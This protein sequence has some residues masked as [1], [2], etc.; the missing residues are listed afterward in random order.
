MVVSGRLLA[1]SNFTNFFFFQEASMIATN[2][3]NGSSMTVDF[4]T[5]DAV[6]LLNQ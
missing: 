2:N 4:I 5:L 6:Q 1:V 3:V